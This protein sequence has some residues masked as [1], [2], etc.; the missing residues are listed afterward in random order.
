MCGNQVDKHDTSEFTYIKLKKS[1]YNMKKQFVK[2]LQPAWF[3][4][5]ELDKHATYCEQRQEVCHPGEVS[6]ATTPHG[7]LTLPW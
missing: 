5:L 4:G 1:N 7:H 2:N 3:S 6:L